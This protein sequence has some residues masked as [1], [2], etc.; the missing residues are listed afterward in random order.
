MVSL[1][2]FQDQLPE[3]KRVVL[4]LWEKDEFPA[5]GYKLK[6]SYIIAA[7]A[8]IIGFVL[9]GLVHA[10]CFPQGPDINRIRQEMIRVYTLHHPEN[11]EKVRKCKLLM[12][13]PFPS[14]GSCQVDEIIASWQGRE[15]EII[16]ALHKKYLNPQTEDRKVTEIN[17]EDT[18]GRND[19]DDDD[20]KK[21]K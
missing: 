7:Y 13:T 4:Q 21:S 14:H 2:T 19:G 9:F 17:G 12:F 5:F 18:A 10:M 6:F 15:G 20:S 11:V 16:D 3:I 8:A 1:K